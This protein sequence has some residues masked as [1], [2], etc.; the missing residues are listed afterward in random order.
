MMKKFDRLVFVSLIFLSFAVTGCGNSYEKMVE[1][2]D[3]K[4]FSLTPTI[5]VEKKLTDSAFTQECML[6]THYTFIKGFE[7]TLTAPMGGIKYLWRKQNLDGTYVEPSLC[8][9]RI[10]TF[11]PEEDFEINVETKL[12]LTVTDEMGTEYIDTTKIVVLNRE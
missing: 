6:E 3:D 11:I 5:G 2:F 1:E 8:E 12:V 9:E 7:S 10:Y 4:Y